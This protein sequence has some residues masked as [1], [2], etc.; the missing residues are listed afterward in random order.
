MGRRA[1][2]LAAGL[3]TRLLPYTRFVPKPLF[4]VLGKPILG[5]IFDELRRAAFSVIGLNTHHLASQIENF[6]KKYAKS[7]PE[8]TFKVYREPEVLGPTG[9]LYGARSFF[10]EPTLVINADI[11]TNFPFNTLLSAHKRFGG[12]AT[13][14]LMAGKSLANVLVEGERLKGFGEGGYTFT[15]LQVITPEL[16]ARLREGDRDLVPTYTRLLAEGSQINCQVVAGFYWRDIGSLSSYLE[17]HEDLLKKRASFYGLP[18]PN[19]PFVLPEE[20]KT[21]DLLLEDWVFIEQGVKI[22]LPAKLK[23]VVAWQGAIIPS[24]SFSD[25]LFI[26]E[27][28]LCQK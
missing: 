16:V 1:F 8:V 2:V 11:V 28:G 10:T 19:S 7:H 25:T 3:G 23:R 18:M 12:E 14:L 9:A 15:G 27:K 22:A 6:V 24:G 21:R 20:I 5:L 13:L 17:V 26:P 4:H